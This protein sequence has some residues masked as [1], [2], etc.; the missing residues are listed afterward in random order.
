MF[1]KGLGKRTNKKG[2]SNVRKEKTKKLLVIG[3][4]E[5]Y[6]LYAVIRAINEKGT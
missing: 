2:F 3:I 6:Y 4:R 1:H 5:T